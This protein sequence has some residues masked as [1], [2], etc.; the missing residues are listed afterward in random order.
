MKSKFYFVIIDSIDPKNYRKYNFK[1]QHSYKFYHWLIELNNF[2][3][4]LIFQTYQNYRLGNFKVWDQYCD[5]DIF[6]FLIPKHT[7]INRVGTNFNGINYFELS[8]ED[9]MY[10]KLMGWV[11]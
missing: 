5:K 7:Y 1:Y 8:D 3:E 6:S 4:D 11:R 2:E 10:M 9:I